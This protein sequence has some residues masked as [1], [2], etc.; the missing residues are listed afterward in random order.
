MNKSLDETMN[1]SRLIDKSGYMGRKYKL[2]AV[3]PGMISKSLFV[4]FIKHGEKWFLT[5]DSIIKEVTTKEVKIR[6]PY[7]V[8]Y[9][10][11]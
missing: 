8:V 2:C 10:R 5:K 1:K 9:I 7:I 6:D 11:I 3:I 4:T